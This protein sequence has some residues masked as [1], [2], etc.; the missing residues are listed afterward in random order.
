MLKPK[1]FLKSLAFVP[2]ILIVL[3]LLVNSPTTGLIIIVEAEPTV[4]TDVAILKTVSNAITEEQALTIAKIFNV[5]GD[6]QS[7]NGSW[8]IT[9]GEIPEY[10]K[11]L[12]IY[13]SGS[14]EYYGN[15][16][17]IWFTPYLPEELPTTNV[18]ISIA[19]QLLERLK[20]E[21]LV[22]Q[23]FQMSFFDVVNDTMSLFD[24]VNDT[25]TRFVTNIHV[26]FNLHYNNVPL[27]GPGA[28]VRVYIGKDGEITG[29]IGNFWRVEPSARAR[30]LTPTQAAEKLRE[31]GFGM[32]VPADMVAKAIVKSIE[33]VYLAPN[34]TLEGDT[35]FIMPYYVIK[36]T[37][38][39]KDG[40][41][42]SFAQVV[43]A[44][45]S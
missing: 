39:A 22:S 34:P 21:G 17:K 13:K 23:S 14:I 27:W 8:M 18:C 32:G 35:T 12:L 5:N 10:S 9:Q 44:V 1:T 20:T 36:G 15:P 37:L 2:L 43:S 38:T 7:F 24:L 6:A 33:L 41:A 31:A 3:T 25:T 45:A 40:S 29:F 19:E 26:N 30:I 16:S 28:K 42:T 4:P 11:K